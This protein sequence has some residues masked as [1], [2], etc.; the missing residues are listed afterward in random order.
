MSNV[1][2][3]TSA[4][5]EQG[6]GFSHAAGSFYNN[7]ISLLFKKVNHSML[8]KIWQYFDAKTIEEYIM[9]RVIKIFNIFT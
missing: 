2:N 9:F 4:K 1:T 7:N 5:K 6:T 3:D 8:I